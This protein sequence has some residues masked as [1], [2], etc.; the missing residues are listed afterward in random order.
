MS[1]NIVV[2]NELSK[3][4]KRKRVL[5]NISFKVKSGRIIGLIGPN[6]AGKSTLMKILLGIIPSDNGSVFIDGSAI[7]IHN[8]S[9][10]NNVGSLIE[11]PEIY[12]FLTGKQHLQM[13]SRNGDINE[14]IQELRMNNYID[15][16]VKNYSLGMKQKL[17]IAIA[18]VDNPSL[19]ILDEPMNGLD[20]I[21]TKELRD[22]I[23]KMNIEGVTFIISSHVLSELEKLVDEVIIINHG[24]IVLESSTQKLKN[25]LSKEYSL[26]VSNKD[27][28]M[29]YEIIKYKS[30][31]IEGLDC[32]I[33]FKLKKDSIL[34]NVLKE[35][36]NNRIKIID[37]TTIN[38]NLESAV[39]KMIS[40][41]EV[42]ND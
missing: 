31:S 29:A 18:F 26:Q 2:V 24:D 14:I 40:D 5:K 6:G 15:K 32:K 25:S 16:S 30:Q 38:D 4:F 39:I 13:Y 36:I 37:I 10:I 21:A 20:P 8:H 9:A 35:L 12:P 33:K 34:N 11:Y 7:T 28:D 42:K 3:K 1:E 27:Y 23:L 17:G 19:V 22:L 41:G